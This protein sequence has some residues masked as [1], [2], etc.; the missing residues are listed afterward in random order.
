MMSLT[1]SDFFPGQQLFSHFVG[2]FS[3]STGVVTWDPDFASEGTKSQV[4]RDAT[5]TQCSRRHTKQKYR[6]PEDP[7]DIGYVRTSGHDFAYDNKTMQDPEALVA[8]EEVKYPLQFHS[9]TQ[10]DV[11]S[12]A[13]GTTEFTSEGPRRRRKPESP[14][15]TSED[16]VGR[17]GSS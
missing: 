4:L 3:F 12:N 17:S 15:N 9:L 6:M 1:H 2:Q 5:Y 8:S 7:D 11:Q 10:S 13:N 14:G 16:W